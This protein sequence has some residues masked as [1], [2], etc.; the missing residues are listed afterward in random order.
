VFRKLF[1]D[2]GALRRGSGW[3]V[4]AADGDDAGHDRDDLRQV[5]VQSW[6]RYRCAYARQYALDGVYDGFGLGFEIRL[7]FRPRVFGWRRV[8]AGAS[9]AGNG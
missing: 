7:E 1:Q 2:L 4:A 9:T 3:E 5:L 8:I 6:C